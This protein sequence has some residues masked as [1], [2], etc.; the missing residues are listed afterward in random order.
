MF[1]KN[2]ENMENNLKLSGSYLE[3]KDYFNY[4]YV[5]NNGFVGYDEKLTKEEKK[6]LGAK[7]IWK[8][9]KKTPV[10][11]LEKQLYSYSDK[12]KNKFEMEWDFLE[13]LIKEAKEQEKEFYKK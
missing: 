10:K 13:Q 8:K 7:L 1:V 4:L 6:L 2:I 3:H 11:T 9:S 12:S 5:T